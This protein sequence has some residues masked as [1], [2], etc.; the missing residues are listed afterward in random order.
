MPLIL[1]IETSSDV[2]SAG[3][4]ENGKIV[5]LKETDEP[6]SHSRLLTILINDI[7]TENN[8][9]ISS[10][11]AVAVSKGPGS[12]TGLRIGVSV[13]KGICYALDK[14]LIA[15]DTLKCLAINIY[16]NYLLKSSVEIDKNDLLICPLVDARRMEVYTAL[17]NLNL[18]VHKGVSAVIINSDSFKDVLSK[19][20]I[21]FGGTGAEKCK[22]IIY[23]PNAIFVDNIYASANYM[24][25][26]SYIS[27]NFKHYE[28]TAYF[29][30]FYLKEFIA[31]KPKE[32]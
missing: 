21:L 23:H 20:H 31:G 10:I 12:Y 7:F 27:F 9:N 14:P 32:F 5:S 29:E 17:Y 4:S 22:K 8:I 24:T 26:L 3:L 1:N 28:N 13:A 19:K 25:S 2:C 11:D 16:E 30:P 6:N 18:E 15:V